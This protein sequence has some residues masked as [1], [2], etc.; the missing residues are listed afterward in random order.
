MVGTSGRKRWHSISVSPPRCW[1]KKV[2]QISCSLPLNPSVAR[3]GSQVG[4]FNPHLHPTK[5]KGTTSNHTR[6]IRLYQQAESIR[7][8]LS[9]SASEKGSPTPQRLSCRS[10]QETPGMLAAPT[11][12]TLPQ[13][14]AAWHRKP[15]N[16][17][18]HTETE[19]AAHPPE[20]HCAKRK[21][22]A[23][24]TL[25]GII[26]SEKSDFTQTSLPFS[27]VLTCHW[28][29]RI[30]SFNENLSMPILN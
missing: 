29:L 27:Q 24:M 1:P 15:K 7:N 30:L 11:G 23:S 22:T 8:P 9:G 6:W 2:T 21:A 10:Q 12:Q 5:S 25:Q 20:D 13:T 4:S 18:L 17:S 26:L 3:E 28:P 16:Q 19:P 14:P